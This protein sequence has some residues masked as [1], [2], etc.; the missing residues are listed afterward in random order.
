[1]AWP[2][3]G[4]YNDCRGRCR[5]RMERSLTESHYAICPS[6]RRAQRHHTSTTG[7]PA[8][9]PPPQTTRAVEAGQWSSATIAAVSCRPSTPTTLHQIP[10]PALLQPHIVAGRSCFA[11]DIDRAYPRARASTTAKTTPASVAVFHKVQPL[12]HVALG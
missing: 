9:G 7:V 6:S 12:L 1:V 5:R 3:K 2:K 8:R 10:A 11:D 4:G